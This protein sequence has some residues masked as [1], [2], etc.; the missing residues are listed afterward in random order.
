MLLS[1]NLV[2]SNSQSQGPTHDR[3]SAE[4]KRRGKAEEWW[5]RQSTFPLPKTCPYTE[6]IYNMNK[7]SFSYMSEC[8]VFLCEKIYRE[9]EYD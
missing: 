5:F 6:Y 8:F 2:L 1:N 7:S 3:G 4:K 9:F